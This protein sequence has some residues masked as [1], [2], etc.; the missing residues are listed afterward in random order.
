MSKTKASRL[1][2]YVDVREVADLA[3]EHNGGSY[4]CETIG[5]AR[6]FS[7]R[8]YRFRKL[9]GEIHH[10]DGSANKY[11]RLILPGI[12]DNFVHFKIRQPVG[13]FRPAAAPS[14]PVALTDE[15]ELFNVAASFRRK[16]QGE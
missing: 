1:G 2:I 5:Q 15:D 3:L 9:Y 10:A 14:V 16:L 11:D 6:N 12:K 7:H 8:F 4:D 13:A